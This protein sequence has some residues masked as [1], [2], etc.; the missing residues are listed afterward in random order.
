MRQIIYNNLKKIFC[1]WGFWISVGI[2]VISTIINVLTLFGISNVDKSM[3]AL[4]LFILGNT[5]GNPMMAYISPFI[6]ALAF[7]P[8]IIKDLQSNDQV[9]GRDLKKNI[10]G[11]AISSAIAGGAV[12]I[13]AFLIILIGCFIYNPSNNMG[14]YSPLGLFKETYYSSVI[15][16]I[17]LFILHSVIFGAIFALFSMG[18]ALVTKGSTMAMVFPG[19]VY[20]C[21]QVVA[22]FFRSTIISPVS[23]VIP[24]LPYEFGSIDAP[25]WKNLSGLGIY[26]IASVILIIYGYI[27]LKKPITISVE[28]ESVSQ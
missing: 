19:I 5:Q 2:I 9:V 22:A 27:K 1:S 8:V 18:I 14:S 26:L 28:S 24:Y 3:G 21:M 4:S 20:N 6:P 7:T 16:Y 17:V 11:H 13:T 15:L 23:L 10:S 25:L 12:F